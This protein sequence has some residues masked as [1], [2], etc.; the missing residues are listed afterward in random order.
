MEKKVNLT[1]TKAQI[2]EA[3]SKLLKQLEEKAA[4]NP[5]EVREREE[6]QKIVE[7]AT[8]N[9]EPVIA[10]NIAALKSNVADVLDKIE[11]N[12]L[13]EYKRLS[14]IR[15]AIKIEKK[16]LEEL[17]EISAGT[18]T[19]AAI[20]LAQKEKKQQFDME[21]EQAQKDLKEDFAA[22]KAAF[23]EEMTLQKTQW[24]AEKKA[25]GFASKEEKEQKFKERKREEEEYKYSLEQNRKK[26]QDAYELKNAV[27]ERELTEKKAAFE[28]EIAEREAS[29]LSAEDELINLRQKA[30]QSPK[31]LENAVKDAEAQIT[32]TLE[33]KYKF[34]KEL[35]AK[36]T[37]GKIKLGEQAI[38]TLQDKIKEQETLIKQLAQKADGSEK[39]VKDIAMKAIES[40]SKTV[41]VDKESRKTGNDSGE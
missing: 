25:V 27:Q 12:L 16:N 3:Y 39:T 38:K 14:E 29:V 34:E 6:K 20:L 19:L 11:E 36:D 10:K 37:E 13:T 1:N 2:L 33:T 18:D 32:Q 30:E 26:E 40:T 24:E 21:M 31:E 8:A 28:K 4:D 17:Y 7:K 23:E 15:E 5:K 22:K 41:I 35:Q 9:N